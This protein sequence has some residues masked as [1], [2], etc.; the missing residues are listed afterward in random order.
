MKTKYSDCPMVRSMGILG[1]KWKPVIIYALRDRKARFGQIAAIVGVISR[2]VLTTTLRELEEDGIISR[3]EY[4][5]LPPRVEYG[6]T[7]KGAALVPIIMQLAKWDMHY[8]G[9]DYSG[10]KEA[11]AEEVA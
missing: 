1:S 7:E 5:E 6:L 11:V 2:K 8:N 4:R 3:I 10:K 9:T